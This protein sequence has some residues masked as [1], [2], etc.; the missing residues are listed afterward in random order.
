MSA[1]RL[2]RFPN[3]KD[4]GASIQLIEPGAQPL[5]EMELAI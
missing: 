5:P 2:I 3:K 4:K 1:M